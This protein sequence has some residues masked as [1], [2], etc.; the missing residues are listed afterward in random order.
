MI[1]RALRMLLEA[2]VLAAFF[3]SAALVVIALT[4]AGV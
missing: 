3:A 2:V 4:P 1:A